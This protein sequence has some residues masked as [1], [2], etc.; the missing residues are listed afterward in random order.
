MTSYADKMLMAMASANR[1]VNTLLLREAIG[2][3][4]EMFGHLSKHRKAGYFECP[5]K[6]LYKITDKGHEYLRS[7]GL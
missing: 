5:K 6:G 1:A 4:P 3:E 2:P 7:K